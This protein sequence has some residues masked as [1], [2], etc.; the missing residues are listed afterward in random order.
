MQ[1][2]DESVKL[3]ISLYHE[4]KHKFADVNPVFQQ[5][6]TTKERF[7]GRRGQQENNGDG[8]QKPANTTRSWETF[9]A[10]NPA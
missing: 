6:E 7:C 8:A 5:M 1:L 10:T 3:L 2:S 9:W 4:H